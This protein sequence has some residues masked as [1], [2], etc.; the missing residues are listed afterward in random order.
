MSEN[1]EKAKGFIMADEKIVIYTD[2]ACSN[3]QE[4]INSGGWGAVLLYKDHYKELFGGEKNT[5]NNRMELMAIIKALEELK[6]DKIPVSIHS[7][8]A[9]IMN[10]FKDKWYEKWRKNGWQNSK[11]Q[12]VENKDLWE[13]LLDLA[14]NKIGLD[15]ITWVKVKGHSGDKYNELADALARKGAEKN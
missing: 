9:Y 6:T 8:S 2:G 14:E 15:K 10:C 11:K 5:T 3:N 1:R 13:K 4:R 12:P 7:D